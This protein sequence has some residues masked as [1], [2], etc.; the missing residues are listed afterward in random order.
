MNK[1]FFGLLIL[2]MTMFSSFCYAK[3]AVNDEIMNELLENVEVVMPE[4]N[5]DYNYE[6]FE[7]IPIQLVISKKI[8]TKKD[9]VFDNEEL[10]FYVKNPVKYK[11]KIIIEKG[12]EVKANV[13]LYMTKGMNGVPACIVVENFKINGIDSKR[14][15]GTYIKRGFNLTPM[16]MPLKWSLTPIPGV[17]S[18]TNF[19]LGGHATIDKSDIITIYYYPNRNSSV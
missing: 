11:N 9:D 2:F 16:V 5:T 19:I 14:L 15:S 12:E 4:A 18:L 10:L 6:D 17:G 7:K 8:S 3:E 13:A 1:L